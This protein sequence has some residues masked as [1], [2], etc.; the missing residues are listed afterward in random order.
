V[1]RNQNHG[2]WCTPR[3]VIRDVVRATQREKDTQ[4]PV[5]VRVSMASCCLLWPASAVSAISHLADLA[6]VF[7]SII[8]S[9][10]ASGTDSLE[11]GT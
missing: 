8:C 7:L 4:M 2:M 5:V 11:T 9:L 10:S 6:D 3:S 1:L